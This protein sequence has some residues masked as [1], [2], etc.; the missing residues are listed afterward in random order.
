MDTTATL[1]WA[2]VLLNG[3][4]Q[5]QTGTG[6]SSIFVVPRAQHPGRQL[7]SALISRRPNS[8][9]GMLV[10]PER[11]ENGLGSAGGITPPSAPY[12]IISA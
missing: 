2:P 6:I 8:S 5:V 10:W 12:N 3:V 1:Y 7:S 9:S 11:F 4:G